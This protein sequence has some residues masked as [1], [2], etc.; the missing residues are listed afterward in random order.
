MRKS[1]DDGACPQNGKPI[2]FLPSVHVQPQIHLHRY[3]RREGVRMGYRLRGQEQI[4]RAI[5][6]VKRAA[7]LGCRGF[8]VYD[9]GC[10]WA[11]N[12]MRKAGEI[13]TDCHFKV[14][15]PM[16]D[17]EIPVLQSY[18]RVLVQTL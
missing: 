10:L 8:L 11:L 15:P 16:R 3:I 18:W 2:L 12:E 17:T 4:V 9:E 7:H 6:D 14:Y 5:E 13:P 1:V